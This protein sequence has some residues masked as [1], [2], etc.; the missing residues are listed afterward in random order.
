MLKK[1]LPKLLEINIKLVGR[2][3]I[4]M[5]MG[6]IWDQDNK[7]N[8]FMILNKAFW[9]IKET[10]YQASKNLEMQL[11]SKVNQRILMGQRI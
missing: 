11:Y 10:E 6:F 4:K 7:C 9:M 1:E 5:E 8:Q 3:V 2:W